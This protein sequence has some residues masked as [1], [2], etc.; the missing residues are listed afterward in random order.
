MTRAVPLVAALLIPLSAGGCV[1]SPPPQADADVAR[2]TLRAALDAWK[3]GQSPESLKG[4]TPPIVVADRDW[5]GGAKLEGYEV[6][7]KDRLLGADLHCQVS[8]TLRDARGRAVKRKATYSVG[9][10]NA[11]TVIRSDDG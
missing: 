7:P 5:Q 1:S 2:Q 6:D 3:A 11:L 10:H 9:T 4:R 8:L